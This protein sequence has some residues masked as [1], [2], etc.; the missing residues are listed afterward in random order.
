MQM[1]AHAV[2]ADHHDSVNRVP[3]RLLNG[4]VADLTA[5][6][7]DTV[8]DLV[9]QLGFGGNEDLLLIAKTSIL[10]ASFLSGVTGFIWLYLVSKPAEDEG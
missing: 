6:R 1:A 9:A 4:L 5:A 10:C 3:R 8:L 2:G 7:G